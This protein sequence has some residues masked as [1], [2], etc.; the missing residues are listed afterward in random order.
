MFFSLI[1][2]DC[3]YTKNGL[4]VYKKV[5]IIGCSG[6]GKSTLALKL[7]EITQIPLYHIDQY[8]LKEHWQRID[9]ELFKRIHK[10]FCSEDRWIIEGLVTEFFEERVQRADII[11]FLDFPTLVCLYRVFKRALAYFGTVHFSSAP[12]C[13]Q[14]V[15]GLEFLKY[16]WNFGKKQKLRIERILEKYKDQK[17]II[18]IKSQKELNT[19]VRYWQKNYKMD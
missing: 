19:F 14:G 6:S 13:I 8:Y 4:N 16:I 5:A 18:I 3:L 12:G 1:I 2:N 10:R 11:I 17:K 7:H 9:P 15:P